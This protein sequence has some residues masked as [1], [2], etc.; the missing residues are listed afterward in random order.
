[1]IVFFNTSALRLTAK[2]YQH[3]IYVYHNKDAMAMMKHIL[4]YPRIELYQVRP[5]L[6]S[7]FTCH[8]EKHH[9]QKLSNEIERPL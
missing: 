2:Q 1:M 3:T 7:F 6:R 4:V 9:I 5:S 8:N